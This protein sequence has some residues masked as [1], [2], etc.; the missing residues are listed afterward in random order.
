MRTPGLSH[1]KSRDLFY[2]RWGGKVRYLGRDKDE[3]RKL[4]ARELVAWAEWREKRD[5]RVKAAYRASDPITVHKLYAR[6]MESKDAECSAYTVSF[7]RCAL[8]RFTQ[9]FGHRPAE[10]VDAAA[11]QAF[12]EQLHRTQCRDPNRRNT[13]TGE[14]L[15]TGRR[16]SKK[17]IAHDIGAVK[18]LIQYGINFCDLPAVN[19]AAVK[20]PRLDPPTKKGYTLAQA[21][22]MVT[23]CPDH[24]APFVR[25]NWL[26]LARP[27]EVCRLARREGE[28][29]EPYVFRLTQSKVGA[30]H[31][32]L[33]KQAMKEL[34]KCEGDRYCDH[35]SYRRA[36][37]RHTERTPHPLRHGA[38]QQLAKLKVDR[39]TIDLILGH[40]PSVVSR[41]YNPID[42][43]ALRRSL[44]RLAI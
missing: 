16:L 22:R 40:A 4:Y 14:L 32:I 5:A 27:E 34:A 28:F 43:R 41:T 44:E 11:L 38:A 36:V 8:R 42:F 33:N 12:K 18:T 3:A 25:I 20:P 35:R 10:I 37:N 29:I 13:R 19:L 23:Q 17:T 1:L 15:T 7:Y 31:L 26:T 6:F 24:L 2:V 39:A 9:W 30:R 21:Q